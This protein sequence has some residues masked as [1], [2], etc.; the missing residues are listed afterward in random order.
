MVLRGWQREK[1]AIKQGFCFGPNFLQGVSF[2][3]VFSPWQRAEETI[4]HGAQKLCRVFSF[5]FHRVFTR[6]GPTCA[7]QFG[8]LEAGCAPGATGA[9]CPHVLPLK[10]TTSSTNVRRKITRQEKS[11]GNETKTTT[12][13]E[14]KRRTTNKTRQTQLYYNMQIWS[15]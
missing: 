11:C 8:P 14:H 6:L 1:E 7:G 4:K 12:N 15:S 9:A 13:T 3:F 10:M 2:L 5:V